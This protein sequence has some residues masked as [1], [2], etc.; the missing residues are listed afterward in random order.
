MKR[1]Q[2][3]KNMRDMTLQEL[4]QELSVLLRTNFYYKWKKRIDS[5]ESTH[6]VLQNRRN[7]ARLKTIIKSRSE[8]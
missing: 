8:T 3:L 1:V 2:Y 7:I 4:N 5:S 6:F